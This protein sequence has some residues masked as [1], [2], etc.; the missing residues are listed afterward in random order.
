MSIQKPTK[1]DQ[2]NLA[3]QLPLGILGALLGGV[4]GFFL[5]QFLHAQGLYFMVLP[6]ALVG[7][8]CGFAA[9]SRS[10]V[11]S[12]IAM[13][14]AI[15]VAIFCEW[16]TDAF[17]CDDGQTLMGIGE[18]VSRMVELRG[19]QLPIF[20]GLNALIALWLGRRG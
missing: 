9:R 20:I 11:F 14:I 15:P 12:I 13:V 5:F 17:F 10:I 1:P 2:S 7:L 3:V 6:G 16:K 4:I 8:G 18:Y 19:K